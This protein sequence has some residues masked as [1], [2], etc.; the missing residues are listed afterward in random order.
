MAKYKITPSSRSIVRQ[1]IPIGHRSEKGVQAIEFDVTAWVGAYGS[2]TLTVVMKRWGDEVP[3]P[4]ALEIDENN[5]ATWT[6]SDT[7]TAKPG[8]AYAQLS[9]VVGDTI[10]KK[11]DVYTLYVMDSLTGEGEP[12]EAYESWLEQLT[13]LAAEAMAEVLDIEGIATDKTLTIDG[14][15]ADAKATGDA[16]SALDDRVD[17]LEGGGGGLSADVK[18]ALM[19]LVNHVTW[20]DDD[21]T[22]QTY[23]TALCNALYPPADL[24]SISAVYTQSGTVYDTDSLDSLKSDIVVTATMSDQTTRTIMDY[25]LSGTLVAGTSTITVSYSGKTTTFTVT[26]TEY[27]DVPSDYTWLYQS[28]SGAVLS[29]DTTN[30]YNVLSQGTITEEISNGFLHVNLGSA[31]NNYY[32]YELLPRTT[33][34]AVL[35]VK[36]RCNTLSHFA[37]T[38]TGLRLLLSNGTSG[39]NFALD[40]AK[41]RYGEGS[42]VKNVSFPTGFDYADW[43]I[44]KL[45]LTSTG[46]Q[47][48]YIDGVQ[49]FDSASLSTSYSVE[50]RLALIQS[51]G[52]YPTDVDI[53]WVA[54]LDRSAS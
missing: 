7:D 51:Q 5:K 15:I 30:I 38:F 29:A 45:E 44:Y 13:R 33:T 2:G 8:M 9:Y 6:F 27:T 4:I 23:I 21:P 10:V 42:T 52:L 43:H 39:A 47:I 14:G 12:P 31:S 49:V 41:I 40:D 18:A 16:L 25:T 46:H 48:G 32:Q 20:D 26:V 36:A 11:S 50:N 35:T 17:A 19:N 53:E 22:G 54:Y 28:S 34:N 24:V 3:Y 1:P 37:N